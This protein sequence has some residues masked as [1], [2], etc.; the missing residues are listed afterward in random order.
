MKIDSSI[1][2]QW[3]EENLISANQADKLTASLKK[4]SAKKASSLWIIAVSTIGAV[5][6]GVAAV[7]FIAANWEELSR[8]EKTFLGLATT[9]GTFGIGFYLA[10]IHQNF[11]K[12]GN[13][14]ILL[15]A[16]LFGGTLMLI[17]QVFHLDGQVYGLFALW[18]AGILPIA[19]LLQSNNV[20]RLSIVTAF[21]TFILFLSKADV[22]GF[23]AFEAFMNVGLLAWF[24]IF[25]FAA[26]S[27]HYLFLKFQAFGKI[28]RMWGLRIALFFLF[29]L[30]FEEI[31]EELADEAIA[32]SVSKVIISTVIAGILIGAYFWK[33]SHATREKNLELALWGGNAIV[34]LAYLLYPAGAASVL[35]FN[36]LFIANL[37]FFL[38]E[39]YKRE[40]QQ[41]LSFAL[42]ATGVFIFGKYIQFFFDLLE[43]ATF[44]FVSGIV[45]IA[46]GFFLEKQR[47]TLKS[48]LTHQ[49]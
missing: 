7:T 48:K 45:L 42:F 18:T 30:T 37:A 21:I 43:G 25:L 31:V 9:F 23:E 2:E 11:P 5:L 46:L 1:I 12:L 13:A 20:L 10:H 27:A 40:N 15:S 28:L 44:F 36:L 47:K 17:S 35:I 32:A 26:G 49:A 22:I 41:L 14:L 8:F 33:S 24:G 3:E 4:A 38:R 29:F 16:I 39:A 34:I 6:L 19:Y